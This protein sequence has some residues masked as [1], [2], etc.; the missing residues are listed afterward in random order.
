MVEFNSKLYAFAKTKQNCVSAPTVTIDD[1]KV[2]KI[3]L[4]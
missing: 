1:R 4:F 3:E 2:E